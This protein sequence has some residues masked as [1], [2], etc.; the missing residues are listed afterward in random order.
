MKADV[1]A[2]APA[3]RAA[4]IKYW[5]AMLTK[6]PRCLFE[7]GSAHSLYTLL[8]TP[9]YTLTSA[10]DTIGQEA[11]SAK[12]PYGPPPPPPLLLPRILTTRC[13]L[14]GLLENFSYVQYLFYTYDEVENMDCTW[15][16]FNALD[17]Q[18][19]PKSNRLFSQCTSAK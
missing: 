11:L 12:V 17:M 10:L 15:D 13:Y 3:T 5:S 16:T 4:S 6:I 9:E 7:P 18:E 14:S 2:N 8:F 19:F 1:P